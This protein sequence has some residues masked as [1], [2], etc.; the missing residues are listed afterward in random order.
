MS[1]INYLEND[2][3]VRDNI[4]NRETKDKFVDEDGIRFV[5][6][7]NGDGTTRKFRR[8]MVEL[9]PDISTMLEKVIIP[10]YRTASTSHAI[11]LLIEDAA[12]ALSNNGSRISLDSR[13]IDFNEQ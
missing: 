12:K 1:E 11:R 8:C 5:V 4:K 2:T 10:F 13:K 9:P 7:V 3:T 6:R